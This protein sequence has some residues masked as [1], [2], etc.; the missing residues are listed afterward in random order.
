MK[1]GDILI[2]HAG[3]VIRIHRVQSDGCLIHFLRFVPK[4]NTSS[5]FS[6]S[7]LYLWSEKFIQANYTE[8]SLEQKAEFL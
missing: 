8:L 2:S 7:V 3:T 5:Y 4:L 6:M 1:S